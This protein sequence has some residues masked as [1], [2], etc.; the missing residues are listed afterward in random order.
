MS[1]QAAGRRSEET[2]WGA[3]ARSQLPCHMAC[4]T[5]RTLPPAATSQ[6]N[7]RRLLFQGPLSA[8]LLKFS[9]KWH[10]IYVADYHYLIVYLECIHL[11]PSKLNHHDLMNVYICRGQEN[12]PK[13][14]FSIIEN[15]MHTAL[16][17]LYCTHLE[18]DHL[19]ILFWSVLLFLM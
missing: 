16:I 18:R 13:E 7:I 15:R 8:L 6:G 9:N 10:C 2:V 14:K 5:R 12:A 3:Q 17:N 4:G 11:E 19:Y 1:R